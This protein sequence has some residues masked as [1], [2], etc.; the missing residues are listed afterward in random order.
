M[1]ASR[2]T[3]LAMMAATSLLAA[4]AALVPVHAG[5]MDPVAFPTTIEAPATPVSAHAVDQADQKAS[6]LFKRLGL[7]AAAGGVLAALI[8]LVGARKVMRV[9][10]KSAGQAAKVAGA[11]AA[12]SAKVAGRV[13]RS[14][15]RFLALTSGLILFALTGVGFY[16]IEW[17]GGMIAGAALAG[18]TAFGMWKT[19]IA[20][21]PVRV[22]PSASTTRQT[23]I[24]Q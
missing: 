24:N 7:I 22:K 13:F 1:G 14:P 10:K 17:I 4:S 6:P 15:I 19:R 9:V 18:L 5:A 16:E 23:E 3:K 12:G 11:A 21:R 8:K 2:K 20:L